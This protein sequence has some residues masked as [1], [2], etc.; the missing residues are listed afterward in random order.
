[1]NYN[2]LHSTMNSVFGFNSDR[3]GRNKD[4]QPHCQEFGLKYAV[5][6]TD[7]ELNSKVRNSNKNK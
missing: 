4:L 7:Q 5:Q 6:T 2:E 1:M 3:S